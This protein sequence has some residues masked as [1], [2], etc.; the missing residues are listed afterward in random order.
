MTAFPDKTAISLPGRGCV[1]VSGPDASAF[2][3]R[4]LSNDITPL[5]NGD[6][7][8]V[9]ACLL[10][11]QGKFLHDMFVTCAEGA[12]CLECEGG[13]RARDLALRLARYRL[14]AAVEI[15]VQESVDVYALPP[16]AS[17]GYPDPRGSGLGR[18]SLSVPEGYETGDFALWDR[19]RIAYG[20]PDG[21]RDAEIEKS[22]LAE[23]NLDR[24]NAVDWEKGCYVGQE[25]TARM[26]YRGLA[27]KR[28]VPVRVAGESMPGF[29]TLLTTTDGRSIGEFRSSSGDLALVLMRLA[30]LERVEETGVALL[31]MTGNN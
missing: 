9:Y 3:Q 15:D 13:A 28:L 8:A 24:L 22:T 10:T 16:S 30:D 17:A 21:S 27:K 19:L 1:C 31:P 5:E 29:G 7:R 20:I 12:F 18:R 14:R 23:L 6:K 11:P 4:L 26:H 2:L 25:L